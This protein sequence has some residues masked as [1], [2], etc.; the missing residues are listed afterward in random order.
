[1]RNKERF[2]FKTKLEAT[3]YI[4]EKLAPLFIGDE[5][6]SGRLFRLLKRIARNHYNSEKL[7]GSGIDFFFIDRCHVDNRNK[8]LNIM[9]VDGSSI[10]FSYR[11]AISGRV[12][13]EKGID[14]G[15]GYVS[16]YRKYLKS[17]RWKK[18]NKCLRSHPNYQECSVVG[19]CETNI[20]LHH[21]TYKNL[22]DD[23][24]LLD[25]VPVC[26]EHHQ[27]IHDLQKQER[28]SI[29]EATLEIVNQH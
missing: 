23:K 13:K 1:M 26:R 22:G 10:V 29:L 15:G 6:R 11:K 14:V 28:F 20:E 12:T 21:T 7:I 3:N 2:G 24:E 19:C 16:N 17:A 27:Q 25:I 5:I 18:I 8:N 4:K 9:R